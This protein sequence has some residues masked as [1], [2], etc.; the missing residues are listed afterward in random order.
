MSDA[1]PIFS[2]DAI[3]L[4]QSRCRNRPVQ[5]PFNEEALLNVVSQEGPIPQRLPAGELN[6]S[7]T[8]VQRAE[9]ATGLERVAF[10]VRGSAPD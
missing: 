9:L 7:P 6:P 4:A 3:F 10:V 5:C 1:M 8:S 2:L